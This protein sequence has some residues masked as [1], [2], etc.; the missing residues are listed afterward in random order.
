MLLSQEG[1]DVVFVGDVLPGVSDTD[2]LAYA[3]REGR[4]LVTDDRDFGLLVFRLQNPSTGVIFL[5]LHEAKPAGR[6]RVLKKVFQTYPLEGYFTAVTAAT[7]RQRKL[8]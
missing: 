6:M 3:E 4:V 1:Y 7:I 5:R 8:P 2:M